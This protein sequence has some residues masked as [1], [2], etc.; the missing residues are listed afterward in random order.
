MAVIVYYGSVHF[1]LHFA[2]GHIPFTHFCFLPWFVYFL[3]KSDESIRNTLYAALVL[4]LMILGNGAAVPFLFTITF[5]GLFF[6]FTS[7]EKRQFNRLFHFCIAT[8]FGVLFSAVKL[9][10][11]VIYL[12]QNRWTGD[13]VESIPFSAL[14]AVFFGFN[15]SL[16]VKNFPEQFYRWH[17]YG[18]YLSPVAVGLILFALW[19]HLRKH[20]VWW[21]LLLIFFL[22]GMGNLGTFSPW[23]IVSHLP[24]YSSIRCSGRFFQFVLLASAVLAGFGFDQLR[25]KLSVKNRVVKFVPYLSLVLI[26]GTNLFLVYPIMSEA[27]KEK[28]E[29]IHRSP[30]FRHV[31]DAKPRAYKNYLANKGSLV[32]PWLSACH[33][34]RGL[35]DARNNVLPEYIVKGEASV[36]KRYYAQ[37]SIEYVLDASS[38][39]EIVFGMGYDR[40]WSS[41][42]G[43]QPSETNR[44]LTMPFPKGKS[45][46]ILTYRTPYF[47]T[48][49]FI[50]VLSLLAAGFLVRKESP[51]L[52]ARLPDD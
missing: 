10:P 13:P 22:L 26:V 27:F 11:M 17:E 38:A 32:T 42:S 24:G 34:S 48:G 35:V 45:E 14:G 4:A 2:E 18:A 49:L 50:S 28:P 25:E 3:L 41:N 46:I 30:V 23:S 44:L 37:N 1:A 39:G 36:E 43:V 7:V 51:E 31:V 47:Y 19:K 5:A 9:L 8:V 16:F 20:M 21:G 40:G 15:Q 33:S 6:L 29:E 52:I 12:W